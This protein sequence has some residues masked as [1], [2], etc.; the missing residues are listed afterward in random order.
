MRLRRFLPVWLLLLLLLVA[1]R[2]EMPVAPAASEPDNS[3]TDSKTI[4]VLH[5]LDS[6]DTLKT[7]FNKDVGSIR[8]VLL[9][10]PT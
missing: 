4:P 1:C 3:R 9:L 2:G 10:S 7:E 8:L 6:L 5:E